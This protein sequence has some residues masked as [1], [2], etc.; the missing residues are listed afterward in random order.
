[1]ISTLAA[2]VSLLEKKNLAVSKTINSLLV[3]CFYWTLPVK[4]SEEGTKEG[5]VE[6][7][8]ETFV[9]REQ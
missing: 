9:H 7:P 5:L 4:V 6:M 3:R 2:L 8:F 1:M